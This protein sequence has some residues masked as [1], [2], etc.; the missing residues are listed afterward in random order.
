MK[1]YPKITGRKGLRLLLLWRRGTVK[2]LT[3]FFKEDHVSVLAT[4][5]KKKSPQLLTTYTED[6]FLQRFPL[7]KLW[8]QSDLAFTNHI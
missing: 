5:K 6:I 3:W 8:I 2:Y 4:Y 7:Q 1:K